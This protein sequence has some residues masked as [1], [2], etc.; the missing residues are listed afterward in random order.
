[1]VIYGMLRAISIVWIGI[2]SIWFGGSEHL[3]SL[4]PTLPTMFTGGLGL[5]LPNC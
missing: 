2:W 4:L 5:W 3:S 1:M